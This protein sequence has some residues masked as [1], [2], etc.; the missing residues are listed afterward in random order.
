LPVF[1]HHTIL[2]TRNS[3]SPPA[4]LLTCRILTPKSTSPFPDAAR[5]SAASHVDDPLLTL[6]KAGEARYD[7]LALDAF[8]SDAIPVHLLTREAFQSYF[9]LLAPGGVIAVHISNQHLDLEPVVAA[10]ANDIGAVARVRRDIL[11]SES[12]QADGRSQAVWVILGRSVD[13]L[14]ALADDERW[15]ALRQRTDVVA[16]TD[17][18]SNIIRVFNWH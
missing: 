8:S 15:R 17:D 12:D 14:G 2:R 10:V 4:Q 18:F 6:R 3:V 16:W 7:I 5:F 9:R 11:I 1:L 13:D